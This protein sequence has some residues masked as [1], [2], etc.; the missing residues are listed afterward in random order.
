MFQLTETFLLS[1][2]FSYRQVF[3]TDHQKRTFPLKIHQNPSGGRA[4]PGPAG[5]TTVQTR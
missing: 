5:E 1:Y 2:N 4:P 3:N